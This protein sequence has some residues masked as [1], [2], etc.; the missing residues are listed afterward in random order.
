MTE[1]FDRPVDLSAVPRAA[2]SREKTGE[3]KDREAREA[4]RRT[5]LRFWTKVI[6]VLVAVLLCVFSADRIIAKITTLPYFNITTLEVTGDLERVPLSR[7][8]E[9]VTPVLTGNYFSVDLE[10]ARS[11]IESVP[12][13]KEA[14]V[15]RLW[16]NGLSVRVEAYQALA[17]YE[18]GRL[19]STEGDLFAANPDER[20]NLSVQ[21]PNFYGSSSQVPLI[22]K[23]YHEFTRALSPLG[24]SVTDLHFSER[25][26]WSL[27]MMS[28]DIPP[29]PIE[30]GVDDGKG[31]VLV[32]L[33]NMVSAYPKMV[34]LMNGP[35][36]SVDMRY[37]KAFAASLPDRKAVERHREAMLDAGLIAE[38]EE[39]VE[40]DEKED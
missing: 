30:L 1:R 17:T 8:E 23:T 39:M 9:A 11:A 32:S 26:S 5:V 27:V 28:T 40:S 31:S 6:A 34:E 38:P 24:A 35:P 22:V 16:P 36:S 20:E 13:V 21:L 2:A 15:R 14:V 33:A 7:I 3:E 10:T 25:G 19:V 12:W 4:V 37:N 18:D 29:T